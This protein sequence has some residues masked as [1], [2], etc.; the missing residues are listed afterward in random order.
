MGGGQ[1]SIPQMESLMAH[2]HDVAVSRIVQG[3]RHRKVR[4]VSSLV[5]SIKRG[6]LINPVTVT[7]SMMLVAGARRLAAYKLLGRA[8]IPA[9]I[10]DMDDVDAEIAEIEENVEREN[11]TE[12]EEAEQLAR[13][14]ELYEAKYPE[15]RHGCAPGSSRGGKD[16]KIASLPPPGGEEPKASFAE[17]VAKK[18]GQSVRAVQGK[19]QT[20]KNL[21]E[22]AKDVVRGSPLEDSQTDLRELAATPPDQQKAVAQAALAG[23]NSKPSVKKAK[24][25]LGVG[26]RKLRK[27]KPPPIPGKSKVNGV[28]VDDPPDIADRRARGLIP[29]D[30]VPDV[31]IPVDAVSA[32]GMAEEE[33]E[34]RAIQDEITNEEW[35]GQFPVRESLTGVQRRIF[36][37]NAL[38]YRSHLESRLRGLKQSL[39]TIPKRQR[40]GPLIGRVLSLVRLDHPKRWL[41]CPSTKEGGCGGHGSVEGT[42]CSF[43][44]GAGFWIQH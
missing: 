6:L 9:Q 29:P 43:C 18:T 26:S 39:G 17:D 38:I 23:G 5:E 13:L 8:M 37:T 22:E 21:T 25:K 14:K 2:F 16:A 10:V 33:A 32:E 20:A 41:L 3:Q 7:T 30:V 34:R 1:I 42:E 36:D 27:P 11:L 24:A 12:L 31:T 44:H 40:R 15:T 4:D 35:L 28:I 19:V